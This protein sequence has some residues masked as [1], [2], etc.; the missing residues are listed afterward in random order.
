MCSLKRRL[1]NIY[2]KIDAKPH[3][4]NLADKLKNELKQIEM[5]EA[6]GAKIRAKITWELEGEKCT[7]YF[8]QKL[9]KRKNADQAILSHKS[10]QNGK[11]LKDQQ[12]VLTKVKTFY[13]QLYGQKKMPKSGLELILNLIFNFQ[14]I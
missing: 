8:F 9:E 10:R 11:I 1:P 2:T 6:Q 7:K 12:E 14:F 3:L 5:K 4:Q 13:E